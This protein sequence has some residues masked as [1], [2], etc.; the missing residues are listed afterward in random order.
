MTAARLSRD[1]RDSLKS[2]RV[3]SLASDGRPS[4]TPEAPNVF[5]L[6]VAVR[7]SNHLRELALAAFTSARE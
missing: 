5:L 2:F 3:H 7:D 4:T 1:S 6:H